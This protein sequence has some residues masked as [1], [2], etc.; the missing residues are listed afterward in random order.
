MFRNY[1][2]AGQK[3]PPETLEAERAS[4]QT[5]T[6]PEMTVRIGDMRALNASFWQSRTASSPAGPRR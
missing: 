1:P 6:A 5:L 2:Q 3:L 4:L